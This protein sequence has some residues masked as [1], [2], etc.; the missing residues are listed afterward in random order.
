MGEKITEEQV[1]DLLAIIRSDASVEVKVQGINNAKSSIK[2]NNVP[3]GCVLNL[4]EITRTA[5]SSQH[6]SLVS[7]GFSTLGKCFC[8]L[9]HLISGVQTFKSI[10]YFLAEQ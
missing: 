8:L 7:A 5:M 6:A 9:Q 1:T 10:L 2:Q 3:D 4:F